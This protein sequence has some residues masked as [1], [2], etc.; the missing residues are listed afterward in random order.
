MP[1]YGQPASYLTL[2]DGTPVV[3]SDGSELGTVTH[4]LAVEEDDIFDGLVIQTGSGHRFVDLTN[5]ER[6]SAG[7]SSV[8]WS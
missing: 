2:A 8:E 5:E 6:P 7:R 3:T 1:D 4:V